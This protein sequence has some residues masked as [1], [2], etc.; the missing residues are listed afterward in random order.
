[1]Y[2]PYYFE[3]TYI[4]VIIGALLSVW[5]S[6]NVKSTYK[7]YSSIASSSGLTG[8]EAARR[9]LEA[10]NIYGITIT[11]ISG[12]M[13]DCYVPSKKELRLSD[14][15]YASTSI[16]GLGIA[17]HE[18]GHAIQDACDYLPLTISSSISPACAV[19]SN[20]GFPLVIFGI[21]LSF[22]VLINVGIL[23]FSLSV[24]IALL[25]LPVEF[26]ASNR[27]MMSLESM[28]I[29]SREECKGTRK[30]LT[31]AGLTY[32]AAAAAAILS[33]LRLLLLSGNRRRRR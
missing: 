30:V 27:A 29:L 20:I 9:I 17:A 23:L 8:A 15:S 18:C 10:N 26:N 11:H 28:G 4:L 24:V 14:S 33:L 22:D 16:A 5:A 1:M 2:Y 25:T 19:G 13:T 7:K 12:E 31:A 6:S 21:V 32:V 3:P